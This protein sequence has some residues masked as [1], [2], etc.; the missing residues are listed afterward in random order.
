MNGIPL[1]DL[2]AQHE[3]VAAEVA[4]GWQEVLGRTAFIGGPQIAAFERE[5]AEFSGVRHC[6]GVGNG[7]DAIEIGRVVTHTDGRRVRF[8]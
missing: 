6:L 4:Q 1:V 2:A 7:T 5:Y 8:G 3:A